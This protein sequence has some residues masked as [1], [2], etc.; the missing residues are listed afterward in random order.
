V[1]ADFLP[2]LPIDDSATWP[3][4]IPLYAEKINRRFDEAGV[5]GGEFKFFDRATKRRLSISIAREKETSGTVLFRI[6]SL[7]VLLQ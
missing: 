4:A 1:H 2:N 7:E 6:R 5:D 3:D